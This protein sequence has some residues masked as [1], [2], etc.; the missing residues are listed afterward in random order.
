MA[1]KATFALLV[2][3]PGPTGCREQLDSHR[4]LRRL[5]GPQSRLVTTDALKMTTDITLPGDVISGGALERLGICPRHGRPAQNVRRQ[6]FGSKTP[7]WVILLALLTLL[8]AAIVAE[9]IRKRVAGP[10]PVCE[11]C[12]KDRRTFRLQVAA[13]WA[14]DLVL[15]VGGA[16]GNAPALVGWLLVTVLGLVFSTRTSRYSVEGIVSRD[17]RFV[18]LKKVDES[19]AAACQPQMAIAGQAS[20]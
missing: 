12:V 7:S 16:S 2:T 19:F 15:L 17:G 13:V 11:Q 14:V 10:V 5:A 4:S 18:E 20:V 1:G 8:V 6:K 9:A 3:A